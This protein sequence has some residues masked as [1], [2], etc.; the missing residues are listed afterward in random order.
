[1]KVS[2]APILAQLQVTWDRIQEI[3][4][5]VPD[6]ILT[7]G[8]GARGK[9]H[10]HGHFRKHAWRSKDAAEDDENIHEV[11]L[12]GESIL[13]GARATLGTLLHEAAH[14]V[15]SVREIQD[16]SRQG[17]YHN[18]K[19]REIGEELGL[20][21]EK[22]SKIGWSVTSV[23]GSTA[24]EFKTEIEALDAVLSI[25][26]L[27][28]PQKEG[29][30]KSNGLVLVCGCERKIRLSKTAAAQGDIECK[31]CDEIFVEKE[32]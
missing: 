6:A 30:A 23:P 11:F 29:A 19:F 4:P 27:P 12:S 10:V 26:R 3:H 31:A 7:F 17:R 15:A 32:Q 24:E 18:E 14:G 20:E 22:D 9:R 16:T 8:D 13:R 28:N 1:M 2:S 25:Y 21:L 5:D